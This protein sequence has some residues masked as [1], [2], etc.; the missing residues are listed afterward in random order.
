M[1]VWLLD[2]PDPCWPSPCP[3][4]SSAVPENDDARSTCCRNDPSV[5]EFKHHGIVCLC[6]LLLCS[7]DIAAAVGDMAPRRWSRAGG[8]WGWLVRALNGV[9]GAKSR[10]SRRE[11]WN[12]WDPACDPEMLAEER[13]GQ[14]D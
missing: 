7:G 14:R 5:V 6:E 13:D 8:Y 9:S 11:R 2:R 12:A 10:V 1:P 3:S 4:T